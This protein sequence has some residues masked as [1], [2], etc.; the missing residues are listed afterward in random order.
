MCWYPV[1]VSHWAV[2]YNLVKAS[3]GSCLKRGPYLQIVMI[4]V[5]SEV[6]AIGHYQSL[7]D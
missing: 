3:L 7:C 6:P 2:M 4:L 1:A 5:V